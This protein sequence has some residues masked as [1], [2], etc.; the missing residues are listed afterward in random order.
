MTNFEGGGEK[1]GRHGAEKMK[2]EG[3]RRQI[4]KVVSLWFSAAI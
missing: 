4:E 3:F 2:V 1:G